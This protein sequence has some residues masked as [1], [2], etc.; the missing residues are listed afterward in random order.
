M[1]NL[2]LIL[3]LL[4]L[5]SLSQVQDDFSDADFNHNPAW[6]GDTLQFQ[7]SNYSSSSWSIRPRLQLDGIGADTSSLYISSVLGNL[8]NMEW[9]FWVR[10][11]FNTSTSN[12][13][14]VYLVS[15]SPDLEGSL[16]GYYV[17]FGD[18]NNDQMD[19]ISLW[20][21]NGT[22]VQKIISGHHAFTGASAN[23]RL[24]VERDNAGNWTLWADATGE[25]NFVL[26][27]TGFDNSV[28]TSS[29]FGVFCKYTSSNKTNFYFDDVYAGPLIVDTVA[30]EV[31]SVNAISTTQL[32]VLFSESVEVGSAEN[33]ANYQVTGMGNA[34]T[35]TK[36]ATI[37]ALVHLTFSNAFTE[38]V[39]NTLNLSGVK[40]IS[41]NQMLAASIPFVY[42]NALQFDI[43]INEIMADPDPPVGL[44]N[45]E[46]LELKNRTPYN[47][48]L[49][50]WTLTIGSSV[51]VF[52]EIS[53]APNDFLIV[54]DDNAVSSLISFGTTVGFSS[55][56]L[57]NT[58]T[59]IFLKDKNDKLIHY[60]KYSDDWY[61][62][63]SKKNGG[64]SLEQI[65]AGNPCGDAD[66]WAVS[67]NPAGGTPGKINSVN[68]SN[69]DLQPPVLVRASASRYDTN[70]IKIYFDEIIDSN[71]I[72][73]V[74]RYS[75]DQGVGNP[76][77]VEPSYPDNK[78]VDLYFSAGFTQKKIYVLTISDSLFD[79]SGNKIAANS[80]TQ[81]AIP[82]L[83][84]SADLVI[85][86]V[87]S[88]PKD[89]GVD[90]VEIYNRS[91]KVLDFKDLTLSSTGDNYVIS[92]DNFLTFPGNYTLLSTNG[93]MVK[94]QYFTPYP[95]SFITMG[96]FPSLLNDEGSVV[97]KTSSGN[98]IDAM[99]YNSDM[100]FPLLSST[101]GV[102]FERIDY[103]R[104]ASDITNWHSAAESVGFATPAYKN[105]QFMQ[106]EA[107]D[108]AVSIYPEI[109]SPDND[110][111]NDVLNINC[112]TESPGKLLNITIYDAKGRLVKYLVKSQYIS[113]QETWSWD[114]TSDNNKKANI[115]IY[116]IY[117][118]LF[119][120]KGKVKH[121][122]RTVV[123]GAKL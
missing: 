10:L 43:V 76:Y 30:P 8:N 92:I 79:C 14:R 114:G 69:P 85:N 13:C 45:F 37:P 39:T 36:D 64:W 31:V 91:N 24:K 62:D 26:E 59:S 50:D 12:N 103:N 15:D 22:A 33:P 4:P 108:G 84:D 73:T 68:G 3:F 101:E 98:V 11:A 121:Y 81:F 117:V 115:G 53:I 66:N 120:D 32:E 74:E 61:R 116:M 72:N 80:S 113:G 56:A 42:Y 41:G 83:P 1:K 20:K 94:S 90:F 104:P 51:L 105:S 123:L 25:N 17:M 18:D 118:E 54:T 100:H 109:F 82:E 97:L 112:K 67:D 70:H 88:N 86:E 78:T 107:D 28:N 21:Q 65:D 106:G 16:N 48:N 23:Y 9:D 96:S 44:P 35:A 19:S 71:L 99:N 111:Y 63:N 119:D 34:A 93:E 27:G 77:L 6:Q 49:K 60:I 52:P 122:Q 2:F 47:L 55:F 110:G 95:W 89:N 38:G 40:D 7:I 46:Y 29:W 102:S 57:S 75:V 5:V 58:G 87:L